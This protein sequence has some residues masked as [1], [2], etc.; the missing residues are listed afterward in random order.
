MAWINT[1][2]QIVFPQLSDLLGF[3]KKLDRILENQKE[4]KIIL[5]SI[6][7]DTETILNRQ[8][9]MA[10]QISDALTLILAAIANISVPPPP[11][12]RAVSLGLRADAP[13]PK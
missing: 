13:I 5:L 3:S 11:V 2:S 1:S 12:D 8:I 9:V 6:K 7:S 4:S 10:G